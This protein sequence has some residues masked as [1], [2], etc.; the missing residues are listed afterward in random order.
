ME[1]YFE[2]TN[3]DI[4]VD[5]ILN[6][7]NDEVPIPLHEVPEIASTMLINSGVEFDD[8]TLNRIEGLDW[9]GL[10]SVALA[11]LKSVALMDY[12]SLV[13]D[14][15]TNDLELE[16]LAIKLYTRVNPTMD[17]SEVRELFSKDP[18]FRSRAITDAQD[19]AELI[20]ESDYNKKYALEN[21]L[22]DT[23]C[24]YEQ[25][26]DLDRSYVWVSSHNPNIK[27]FSAHGYWYRHDSTHLSSFPLLTMLIDLPEED[28]PLMKETDEQ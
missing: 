5:N 17:E 7:D 6:T 22:D 18:Q 13:E 27:I 10:M 23:L 20:H 3:F 8:S 21:E 11:C 14:S 1:S 9:K 15:Y 4:T 12:A 26:W 2:G 25:R 16:E 28:F 19:I 24:L